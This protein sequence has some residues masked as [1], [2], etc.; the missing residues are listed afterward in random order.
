MEYTKYAVQE[1]R[2]ADSQK[3]MWIQKLSAR[4]VV[5][6][7]LSVCRRIS[8]FFTD[9]NKSENEI[10]SK[11]KFVFMGRF[12]SDNWIRAHIKP[13][14][15]SKF[16]E[17]I[18]IISD[19]KLLHIEN[20][21]YIQP[22]PLLRKLF[23]DIVARAYAA[24]KIA[25]NNNVHYVGGFH[26]LL[27]GI[28]AHVIAR[29]NHAK[30]IYFCVGGW[31]EVVGGGVYS[32]TPVFKNL[33]RY[34]HAVEKKLLGFIK[35]IDH[36]ITM[37]NKAKKYFEYY[38]IKRVVV[39]PGG[40]D[41]SALEVDVGVKESKVDLVLV[42][43]LDPVK[44]IDRFLKIVQQLK[45]QRSNISAL[46]VGGGELIEQYRL[47]AKQLGVDTNVNFIGAS[48]DV[49]AFLINAKVFV[50]TSD[51]EGLPLSCM[52]AATFGLPIVASNIG[53][54][55]DLIDNNV[56]GFLIDKEDITGFVDTISLLL[57]DDKLAQT[58]AEKTRFK[59]EKFSIE[60][61]TLSWNFTIMGRDLV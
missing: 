9:K 31:S 40:I 52:E 30:S 42:A 14:A 48:I 18:W 20:V 4:M 55:S 6:F 10:R 25:K 1:S 56:D 13:L 47:L 46:I 22:D 41:K 35:E 39:I 11:N 60:A 54:L 43:R 8:F 24:H 45:I 57:S 3:K 50:L 38:G 58:V 36:V 49:G 27:N 26:L 23:G 51:S 12:E 2:L 21:T 16:C 17:H 7:L 53:D 32:G 28:F 5:W 37:G 44:R 59:A 33:G 15:R 34:D 19:K 61:A 29:M